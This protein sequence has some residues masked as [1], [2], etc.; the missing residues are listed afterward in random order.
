[1]THLSHRVFLLQLKKRDKTNT[2]IGIKKIL[3]L[4]IINF[5]FQSNFVSAQSKDDLQ[6]KRD[7]INK[8]IQFTSKLINETSKNKEVAQSQLKL[9]NKKISLQQELIYSISTEANKINYQVQDNQKRVQSLE[10]EIRKLKQQYA[11]MIVTAYRN[12]SSYD[13]LMYVFAAEDFYQAIKRLRYLKQ[14]SSY[15]VRQAEVIRNSQFELRNKIVT[16]QQ[17]KNEKNK[18]LGEQKSAQ[19]ELTEDK[20]VQIKSVEQLQQEEKKLREQLKKQEREKEKLN[21]AIQKAIDA[22][23][24]ASKKTTKG[25][26]AMAPEAKAL[27]ANFEGNKGKL[28]WPVERGVITEK[29]GKHP[30][31]ILSGIMVENNGVDISTT[32]DANVRSIFKGTVS[33]VFSIPGAGENIIVSHGAYRTV[34]SQLSEVFVKKGDVVDVKQNIGKILADEN[35]GKSEAHLEIWKIEGVQTKKQNPELWIIK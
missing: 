12:R 19:V 8:D 3:F 11:S 17:Q 7:K 29:F 14:I 18:L 20:K 30:H 10:E 5:I 2:T 32:K 26:V 33:S 27:S 21:A 25:E 23:I 24:R 4:I 31:P 35:T 9:L 1:L 15:R 28:P 16:L 22:E 13:K 6:K 34:Y